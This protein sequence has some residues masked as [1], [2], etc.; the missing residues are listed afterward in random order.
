MQTAHRVFRCPGAR[1][2]L[3][4]HAMQRLPP[5]LETPTHRPDE[6][7]NDGHELQDVSD[8]K[9]PICGNPYDITV[10]FLPDGKREEFHQCF[11]CYY[12]IPF[13]RAEPKLELQTFS[14]L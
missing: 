4:N 9:C 13:E 6:M 14:H 11:T 1:Q 12:S 2:V 8:Q 3:G 5:D 10:F 7:K